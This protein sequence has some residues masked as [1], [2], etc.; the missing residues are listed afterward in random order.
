MG[1]I[2]LGL[3]GHSDNGHRDLTV[4]AMNE[5][6]KRLTAR[7][8]IRVSAVR[9]RNGRYEVDEFLVWTGP[10]DTN[11]YTKWLGPTQHVPVRRRVR[12]GPFRR[13][14][15]EVNSA[16]DAAEE[17]GRAARTVAD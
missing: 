15:R 4:D 8:P 11:G 10:V 14:W 17:V 6:A 13:A 16:S 7:Y 1:V 3:Q 9:Y 12:F 5:V 2:A